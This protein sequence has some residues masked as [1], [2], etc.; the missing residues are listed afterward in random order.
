MERLYYN[1][2]EIEKYSIIFKSVREDIYILFLLFTKLESDKYNKLNKDIYK[3][4]VKDLFKNG[5]FLDLN[6]H[7]LNQEDK[8][9]I[10]NYLNNRRLNEDDY[11][12]KTVRG[13]ILNKNT[14]YTTKTYI[15]KYNLENNDKLKYL[16][17]N[18]L[19]KTYYYN[20]LIT[21]KSLKIV[22]N[23]LHMS[24]KQ[25]MNF[26]G[27]SIEDLDELISSDNKFS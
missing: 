16:N 18:N 12:L 22:S 3:I 2:P 15:D 6:N 14:I 20:L 13:N 26:L 7:M 19:I 17:V 24:T 23:R 1:G 5:K 9:F 11:I 27:I 4:R 25:T 8:F 21:K 10:E